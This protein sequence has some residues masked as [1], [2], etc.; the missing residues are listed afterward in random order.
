MALF[1]LRTD[2]DVVVREGVERAVDARTCVEIKFRAPHAI[3]AKLQPNSLVDSTQARTAGRRVADE[4]V[5]ISA[6][7]E[8]RDGPRVRAVLRDEL[9]E[10][11]QAAVLVRET[12]LEGRG[13]GGERESE[14]GAHDFFVTCVRNLNTYL[15]GLCAFV[16]TN[17]SRINV[18]ETEH[19]MAELERRAWP[20]AA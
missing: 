14:D 2:R 20:D 15:V 16:T 19:R 11:L 6:V 1:D 8:G 17:A 9:A 18:V 4:G 10:A 13:R 12:G 3:D 5:V 7:V